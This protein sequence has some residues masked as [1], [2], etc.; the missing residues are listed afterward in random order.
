MVF[1]KATGGSIPLGQCWPGLLAVNRYPNS[2]VF[3]NPLLKGDLETDKKPEPK[4]A[5][6]E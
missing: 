5:K 6:T 3:L 2:L 1:F 4:R